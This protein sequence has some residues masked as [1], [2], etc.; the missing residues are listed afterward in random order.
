MWTQNQ[1]AEPVVLTVV[2]GLHGLALLGLFFST[3]HIELKVSEAK[4]ILASI[5]A[6]SRPSPVVVPPP[7]P[8][9][10]AVKEPPK[11]ILTSPK[12]APTPT[13]IAPIPAP[14]KKVEPSPVV[15][16]KT[17]SRA[18]ASQEA[19][20]SEVIQPKFDADYLNN[21]KP[22]YPSIS[23][24][25]GEEG[26]VMLRV[27]VNASG[28]PERIEV[29]RSSGFERLDA[30]ALRAVSDW[31]FVPARQGKISVAAWVQVPVSFQLRR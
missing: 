13:P 7:T 22:A 14:V 26:V 12:P 10:P 29:N 24:R 1:R 4:P 6:P 17:D 20:T 16:Q 27:Y 9:K 31:K 18:K 28:Q 15:E 5:I 3:D 19:A 23:R 30:A 21:P 11:K 25:L 8:T 2:I